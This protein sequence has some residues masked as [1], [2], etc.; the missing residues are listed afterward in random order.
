MWRI[1]IGMPSIDLPQ[2]G[3]QGEGFSIAGDRCSES[4][5]SGA[6]VVLLQCGWLGY[7]RGIEKL[8]ISSF[9]LTTVVE[10]HWIQRGVDVWK[11]KQLLRPC[12]IL[13]VIS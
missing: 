4:D 3:T 10:M 12:L 7:E 9:V 13:S 1:G 11:S 6:G 8:W 2:G 5:D